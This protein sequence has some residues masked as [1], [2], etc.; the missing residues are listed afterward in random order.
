M[1]T[2]TLDSINANLS[3]TKEQFM[4]ELHL[5]VKD[6]EDLLQATSSQAGENASAARARIQKSL[7][8]VKD[9]LIDT[10]TEVLERTRQAAKVTDLYVHE[11]PWKAIGISACVGAIVGM[12]IARR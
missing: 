7:R 3:A 6:A 11:N 9:R 2:N 10:E 1:S 8:V 4:D 12:L 5:M